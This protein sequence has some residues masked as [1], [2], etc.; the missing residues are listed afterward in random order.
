MC[1]ICP[2]LHI[3]SLHRAAILDV[4]TWIVDTGDGRAQWPLY[5]LQISQEF[6]SYF[7][8]ASSKQN[9]AVTTLGLQF[10]QMPWT[11]TK[12]LIY[13]LIYMN[14]LSYQYHRHSNVCISFS[15]FWFKK[16]QCC[17]QGL[18]FAMCVDG[19][20]VYVCYQTCL[21]VTKYSKTRMWML[22]ALQCN[23][24]LLWQEYN[25]TFA[26]VAGWFELSNKVVYLVIQWITNYHLL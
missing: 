11:S 8:P 7:E 5:N 19:L 22:D 26:E 24:Q 17:G 14:V 13:I 25:V 4:V 21:R 9:C 1:D 16:C 20:G 18:D 6:A 23:F 15:L 2:L 12:Q 10:T 3:T